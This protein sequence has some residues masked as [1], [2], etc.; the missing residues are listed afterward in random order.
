MVREMVSDPALADDL[1]QDTLE[2]GLRNDISAV[3]NLKRWFRGVAKNLLRQS[4]RSRVRREMRESRVASGGEAPDPPLHELME[5]VEI[6]QK[7]ASAVLELPLEQR[8]ILILR[9]Y[10]Q[11]TV[12]QIAKALSL[13]E[14]AAGLRIHRAKSMLRSRLQSQLGGDW[15]LLAVPISAGASKVGVATVTTSFFAMNKFARIA[16]VTVIGLMCL[17][18]FLP[19]KAESENDLGSIPNLQAS[20]SQIEDLTEAS[21]DNAEPVNA[22][23]SIRQSQA[24]EIRLQILDTSG[25]GIPEAKVQIF[26]DCWE[27]TTDS[28]N[29]FPLRINGP[30]SPTV[31]SLANSDGFV[32]LPAPKAN[33]NTAV[34]AEAPGFIPRGRILRSQNQTD[35]DPNVFQGLVLHSPAY[36]TRLRFIDAFG[37]PIPGLKVRG[38]SELI[39]WEGGI[40]SEAGTVSSQGRVTDQDGIAYFQ[41][42]AGPEVSFS[43]QRQGY[44]PWYS[45]LSAAVGPNPPLQEFVLERGGSLRV[46]VRDASGDPIPEVDV[47]YT[48]SSRWILDPFRVTPFIGGSLGKTDLDGSLE[49]H[50]LAKGA[51][52][53]VQ[54]VKGKTW[55]RAH[56]KSLDKPLVFTWPQSFRLKGRFQLPDQ[57]PAS[58]AKLFLISINQSFPTPDAMLDLD[59][60]GYFAVTLPKG[61]YGFEVNH[62]E[63][64]FQS[65]IPIQLNK[66]RDLGVFQLPSAPI[67]ELSILDSSTNQHISNA[68]ISFPQKGQAEV[69]SNPDGWRAMLASARGM[70]NGVSF[71]GSP[72]KTNQIP[73]GS[74]QLII[75]APGYSPK[76]IPLELKTGEVHHL[77]IGLRPA[78]TLELSFLTA[79]GEPLRNHIFN[80]VNASAEL[81]SS[82]R[83]PA[84]IDTYRTGRTDQ[85][86]MLI[87]DNLLPGKWNLEFGA[88]AMMGMT[89]HS[90]DLSPGVTQ[91]EVVLPEAGT[92]QFELRSGDQLLGN[93]T[94]QLH[95]RLNHPR[96]EF[97]PHSLKAITAGSGVVEF[98]NVYFDQYRAT[99]YP[100]GMLPKEAIIHVDSHHQVIP[101]H[102]EG[103]R[104]E[105]SIRNPQG[106]TWVAL[107]KPGKLGSK[108]LDNQ[109]SLI[110]LRFSQSRLSSWPRA[111][112]SDFSYAKTETDEAGR[113]KFSGISP[114]EYFV[115]AWSEENPIVD[116]LQI[117]VSE[118]GLRGVSLSLLPSPRLKVEVTGLNEH[119]QSFEGAYLRARISARGWTSNISLSLSQEDD[120]FIQRNVFPGEQEVTFE[121]V[122]P[123]SPSGHNGAAKLS[124][125]VTLQP[126]AMTEVALD[127]S[128]FNFEKTD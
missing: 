22:A 83:Y 52:H 88:Q 41:S 105:G 89:L 29:G 121:L 71:T 117:T 63:G 120:T 46:E 111:N 1:A 69:A 128:E 80:L 16:A 100:D 70:F 91:Q 45:R 95:R 127:I 97:N 58:H 113:F 39:E 118:D 101:V 32:A 60:S 3:Q 43:V 66:N 40:P 87:L 99:I 114:G 102:F 78:C 109:R 33:I 34:F 18:P 28:I 27:Q 86:G 21:P 81:F 77:E 115:I 112:S 85:N 92:V 122:H 74:N 19:P 35:L 26:E 116:P 17:I 68:K 65:T 110:R 47:Y 124:K 23:P 37:A 67:L 104:V 8:R 30:L 50:G 10:E 90:F 20:G 14:S 119:R 96:A 82:E 44:M 103:C 84:S 54:L 55:L 106:N 49:I 126:G 6:Q 36:A 51:K 56:T 9:Y 107:I 73:A 75:A 53:R 93:A 72:I 2:V 125:P 38:T 31:I 15:R 11:Q 24:T 13:S 7:V 12:A 64:A 4:Y 57:T 94:A 62:D 61:E 5:R 42:L 98:Q 59:E 48:D 108:P 123:S 76:T 79:S 25:K